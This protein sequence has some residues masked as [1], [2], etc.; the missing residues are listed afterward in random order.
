MA[1]AAGGKAGAGLKEGARPALGARV[2]RRVGR[3]DR[4][5]MGVN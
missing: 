1:G 3:I 4:V 5:F 2:A